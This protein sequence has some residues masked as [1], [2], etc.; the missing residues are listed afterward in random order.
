[1]SF[2]EFILTEVAKK[3]HNE[4]ELRRVNGVRKNPN[5]NVPG[6]FMEAADGLYEFIR[7]KIE[8]HIDYTP[9]GGTTGKTVYQIKPFNLPH[10]TMANIGEV[11]YLGTSMIPAAIRDTG[12]VV[13]YLPSPLVTWY[14]KY[15]EAK[16]GLNQDY[17]PD[18]MVIKEYP[19]VKIVSVPNADNHHRVIWT[20]DGNIKCY[21]QKAGEMLNFQI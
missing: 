4:R 20:I 9:D 18:L 8:G 6:R 16:Y 21:E 14:H 12:N 19:N 5:P 17:K 7:K 10:I 1:M 11:L 15:N 13:C 3:L 2:I